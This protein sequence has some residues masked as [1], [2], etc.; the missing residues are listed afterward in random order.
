MV[1]YCERAAGFC[2][3]IGNDDE[4]Y[5]AALVRMFEQALLVADRLPSNRRD[6]LLARLDRVREISETF[7]YGVGD[8][9][10]FI[11]AKYR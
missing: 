7:G 5:F 4:S 11:L 1:F 10:D 3:D 6:G 2:S 9:M 8:N